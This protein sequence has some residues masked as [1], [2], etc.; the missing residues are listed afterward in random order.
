MPRISIVAAVGK[1]RELGSGNKLLWHIPADLKRFKSLTLGHPVIMG[2][3]TFD[4]IVG[5]LGKPLPERKNIVM[6]LDPAY[7]KEWAGREDVFIVHSSEEA[8]A[9]ARSLDSEEIFIGGGAQIYAALLPHAD[10]LYLTQIE[11]DKEADAFFPA[12][13][14]LFTKTV[15]EEAGKH[16]GLRYRWVTL[17]K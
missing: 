16:E 6:T 17:E 10:R 7:G 13:E 14:S 3:K 11:D 15:S 5:M 12:Y 8:L 2:Q 1:N 9:K 4:S